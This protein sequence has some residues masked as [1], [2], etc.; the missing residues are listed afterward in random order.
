MTASI[1]SIEAYHEITPRKRGTWEKAVLG[2]IRKYG[3]ISDRA[4]AGKIG[5]ECGFVSA[6]R[7]S[8][9]EKGLVREAGSSTDPITGAKVTLWEAY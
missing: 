2:C 3:P 7:N 6:R 4:I 1:R 5:K 8:L 9:K